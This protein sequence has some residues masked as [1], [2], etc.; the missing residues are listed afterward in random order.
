MQN[1]NIDGIVKSA[2]DRPKVAVRDI[3]DHSVVKSMGRPL[4]KKGHGGVFRYARIQG[5]R[6]AGQQLK[7]LKNQFLAS[8]SWAY[9]Q[10][11]VPVM[12]AVVALM[13]AFGGGMWSVLVTPKSSANDAVQASPQ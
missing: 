13:L 7:V 8:W 5:L 1:K 6:Y 4:A 9:E 3:K 12:A 2:R 11:R 10:P